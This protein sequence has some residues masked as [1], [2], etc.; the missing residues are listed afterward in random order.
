MFSSFFRPS[1]APSV[2]RQ[3]PGNPEPASGRQEA[4]SFAAIPPI[5]GGAEDRHAPRPGEEGW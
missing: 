3:D 5:G 4:A 1:P 2:V